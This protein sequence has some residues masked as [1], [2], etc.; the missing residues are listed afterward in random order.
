MPNVVCPTCGTTLAVTDA[1]LGGEV[2]CGQCRQVFRTTQA[3]PPAPK[4]ATARRD[5][6]DDDRRERPTRRRDRDDDREDDD[7]PSRRRSR[8]A[9]EDDDGDEYADR[10]RTR[11][12]DDEDDDR[13]SSRGGS[14]R[15]TTKYC[16]ECGE[17]IRKAAEICPKCGVRQPVPRSRRDDDDDYEPIRRHGDDDIAGKKVIAGV[18]GILFGGLGIHKFILGYGGAGAVMLLVFLLS[19]PIGIIFGGFTCGMGCFLAVGS[20]VMSIIGFIEGIMY[21][22]KSD[23]EFRREHRRLDRPW[24]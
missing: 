11:R 14:T 15:S 22:C 24:F 3:P 19:T 17:A 6:E 7:R 18:M 13:R 12:E 4:R 21:L 9:R 8:S 23:G 2:Q 5:D 20:W 1:M 16:H 10:R